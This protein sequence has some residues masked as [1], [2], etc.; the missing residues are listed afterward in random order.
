MRNTC[1]IGFVFVLICVS[2]FSETF[3]IDDEV[4]EV[5]IKQKAAWNQGDIDSFMKYY[6]KSEDL[7]FQSGNNRIAGW[8]AL[9]ARYKMNYSGDSMGILNF[10]DIMVN[11][12]TEDLVLVLGYWEV[13]GKEES[14]GGLFTLVLQLKPEGWRIIHDHTSS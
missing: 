8:D 4:L 12:L 14:T 13:K 11:V 2:G 1:I 3:D 9:L 6:W 7:T 5:L 10:T